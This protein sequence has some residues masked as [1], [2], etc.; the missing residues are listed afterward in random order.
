METLMCCSRRRFTS[1]LRY[2]PLFLELFIFHPL[3]AAVISYR[4][5]NHLTLTLSWDHIDFL[6]GVIAIKTRTWGDWGQCQCQATA[7][8]DVAWLLSPPPGGAGASLI[9]LTLSEF[10]SLFT[11]RISADLKNDWVTAPPA[12]EVSRLEMGRLMR[13]SQSVRLAVWTQIKLTHS[14]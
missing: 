4:R 6:A 1:H 9:P 8:A 13:F 5:G 10:W 3:P 14:D 11:N 12:D 2:T 7:W